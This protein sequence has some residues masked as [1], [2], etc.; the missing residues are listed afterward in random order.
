MIEDFV[1]VL[2]ERIEDDVIRERETLIRG[3]AKDFS[4]YRYACGVVRGMELVEQHVRDL[5]QAAREADD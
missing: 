2:R 3:A 5:L 1:R 4:E